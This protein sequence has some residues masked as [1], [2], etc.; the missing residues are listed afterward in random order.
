MAQIVGHAKTTTEMRGLFC[1]TDDA[2]PAGTFIP[3]TCIRKAEVVG[4]T[5]LS[6]E[7]NGTMLAEIVADATT[8][9]VAEAMAV[10]NVMVYTPVES[11]TTDATLTLA[12]TIGGL[13]EPSKVIH[14]RAA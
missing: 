9:Y 3:E 13:T 5:A 2:D 10:L 6:T 7:T 1:R 12:K 8:E 4:A 11:L 14:A